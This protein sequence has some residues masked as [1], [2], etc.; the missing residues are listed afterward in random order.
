MPNASTDEWRGGILVSRSGVAEVTESELFRGTVLA[1]E[2]IN[3]G[4]GVLGRPIA[5]ICYDPR[6]SP[7]EYRRLTDKLLIEDGVNVIFGCMMS[8]ARKAIITSLER[9]NG[10]LMY[11]T[12]YEG[13]EYSPNILYT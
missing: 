8:A 4:G 9:R 1:I 5:P 6:S 7:Y 11:P 13:F 2:Q 12:N 3:A 10:L